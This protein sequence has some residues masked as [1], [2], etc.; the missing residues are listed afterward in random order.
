MSK[1]IALKLRPELEATAEELRRLLA[2]YQADPDT[3][4]LGEYVIEDDPDEDVGILLMVVA[5]V[6]ENW[7]RWPTE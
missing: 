6:F 2:V 5:Q 7:P 1:R 3:V 4:V